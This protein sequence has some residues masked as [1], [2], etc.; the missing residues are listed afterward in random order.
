MMLAQLVQVV[1]LMASKPDIVCSQLFSLCC[2]SA[3][4]DLEAVLD[5]PVLL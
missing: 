4:V 1:L 5:L 3:T 2:F